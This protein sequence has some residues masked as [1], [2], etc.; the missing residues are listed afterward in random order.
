LNFEKT[1]QSP[2]LL[3]R[4]D[5]NVQQDSIEESIA[6]LDAIR[7]SKKAFMDP[8]VLAVSVPPKAAA[9]YFRRTGYK[10]RALG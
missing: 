8:P 6:A 4:M 10:G 5:Q 1:E 2:W 9:R 7:C 3:E